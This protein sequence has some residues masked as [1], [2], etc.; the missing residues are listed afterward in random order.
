M[1]H[2]GLGSTHVNR[3]LSTINIP[4]PCHKTSKKREREV[5]P[6]IESA[7]KRSCGRTRLEEHAVS[8]ATTEA[9]GKDSSEEPGGQ[10]QREADATT[11]D[12]DATDVG[13]AI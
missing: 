6:L 7:A 2:A 13:V 5:G 12:P 8:S 9:A 3:F 11:Q 1:L 10:R 4:A